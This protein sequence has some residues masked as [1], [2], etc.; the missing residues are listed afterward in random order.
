LSNLTRQ[1]IRSS[2]LKLLNRKPLDKITVKDIVEDCGVN[3]NTFYYHYQDIYA[4]LQDL[5]ETEAQKIHAEDMETLSA[6][7]WKDGFLQ[8]IDF[9]LSNKSAIFHVFHSMKRETLEGY[10]LNIADVYTE[11]F[12]QMQ[13]QGLNISREDLRYITVFYKHAVV[14]MII[15]WLQRDMKD[16]P[17]AVM[18]RID[19]I[20]EGSI[21]SALEKISE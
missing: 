13:A 17:V 2:F 7:H 8:V 15:E 16:D 12:V 19:E 18:T 1:A 10:L 9:A 14:G 3:R 5:F 6:R 21:R 4:L 20:F 11:Q